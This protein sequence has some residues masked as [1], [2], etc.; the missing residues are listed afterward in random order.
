MPGPRSTETFTGMCHLHRRVNFAH[1][2]E[3]TRPPETPTHVRKTTIH[4]H[5]H[6]AMY[7]AS[8]QSGAKTVHLYQNVD[9]FR[10]YPNIFEHTGPLWAGKR[11]KTPPRAPATNRTTQTS[12][13]QG[14]GP[15]TPPRHSTVSKIRNQP[16]TKNKDPLWAR[17]NQE[18]QEKVIS[19]N[20][21]VP[22]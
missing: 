2:S 16:A 8:T 9:T 10:P 11:T 3:N 7:A 22:P 15:K 4:R 18:D 20:S 12:R 5:G 13:H 17:K 21:E 6:G 1:S 19:R 14:N